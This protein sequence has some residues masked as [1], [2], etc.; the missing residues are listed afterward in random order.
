LCAV[1]REEIKSLVEACVNRDEVA[2][3]KFIKH[4]SGLVGWSA[5]DRLRRWR[6]EFSNEDVEDIKQQVFLSIWEKRRLA[7][8]KDKEKVESWLAIV[9]GNFAFNYARSRNRAD[10]PLLESIFKQNSRIEDISDASD[11]YS[12]LENSEIRNLMNNFIDKFPPRQ[13]TV[14]TLN[15]FYEKKHKEIAEILKIPINTVSTIIKRAKD[16][17]RGELKAKGFEN[18]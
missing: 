1:R 7:E 18:E 12:V 5:L 16:S 13:K 3:S 2:W 11:I 9:A 15:Y 17:L 14:L 8:I 6:I 4:F 10:F